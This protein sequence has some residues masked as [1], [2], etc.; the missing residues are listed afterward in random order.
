M[1]RSWSS[2]RSI[3]WTF[4]AGQQRITVAVMSTEIRPDLVDELMELYCEW[5]TR[6]WDVRTAYE[7]F[8]D[9]PAPDRA[10]AFAAYTAALDQEESAC[11]AY[12]AHIRAIQSRYPGADAH[13]HPSHANLR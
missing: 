4:R 6:C 12:A 11:D 9:A 8:L 1:P 13:A 5:R 7:Q 10:V 2:H 3:D